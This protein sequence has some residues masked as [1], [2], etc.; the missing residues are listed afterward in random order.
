MLKINF[1]VRTNNLIPLSLL[2]KVRYKK[3]SLDTLDSDFQIDGK[4]FQI[5]IGRSF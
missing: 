5:G 3:N 2:N 1:Q 4:Q